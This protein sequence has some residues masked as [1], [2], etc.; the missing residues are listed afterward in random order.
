MTS[1]SS[2]EEEVVNQDKL[3]RKPKAKLGRMHGDSEKEIQG[4]EEEV[5]LDDIFDQ[6]T[7][8]KKDISESFSTLSIRIDQLRFELTDKIKLVNGDVQ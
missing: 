2:L 7:S 5:T 4:V 6:I 8:L 1:E 3:Q